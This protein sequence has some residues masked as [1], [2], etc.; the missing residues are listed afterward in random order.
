MLRLIPTLSPSPLNLARTAHNARSFSS[1]VNFGAFHA[2][3]SATDPT[4]E[5]KLPS[6]FLSERLFKHAEERS[7]V[8]LEAVLGGLRILDVGCGGGILSESLAKSGAH[9]LGLDPS[10]DLIRVAEHHREQDFATFSK[11]FGLRDDRSRNVQYLASTL[12]DFA[13]SAEATNFDIVVAS[14]VLEHVPNSSKPAFIEKLSQVVRPGGMSFI[15][16]LARQRPGEPFDPCHDSKVATN[17]EYPDSMTPPQPPLC[18]VCSSQLTFLIQMATP[19]RD[20]H[21]RTLYVFFCPEH[22]EQ[23]EGWRIYRYTVAKEVSRVPKQSAFDEMNS[24]SSWVDDLEL[25]PT[26]S[27]GGK[28]KGASRGIRS[29]GEDNDVYRVIVEEDFYTPHDLP[30]GEADASRLLDAYK[31]RDPAEVDEEDLMDLDTIKQTS[32][33]V[34]SQQSDSEPSS[35][36]SDE[37]QADP[38]LLEFQYYVT[39]RPNAVGGQ[40]SK[41]DN[42]F[43]R[44]YDISGTANRCCCTQVSR[45]APVATAAER[46]APSNS[47]CCPR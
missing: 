41:R 8:H 21:L 34:D 17:P 26:G 44:C 31:H 24:L 2:K 28:Q 14:E 9:V 23:S 15:A 19:Y 4:R 47:N 45:S 3:C 18:A 38:M 27:G 25:F 29:A 6:G 22:S 13:C 36:E 35:D 39:M 11:R 5:S 20:T 42:G 40:S 33:A 1:T 30:I 7:K 46:T 10:K 43:S 12:D 16:R 37:V 32:G